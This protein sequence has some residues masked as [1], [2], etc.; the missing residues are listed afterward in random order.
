MSATGFASSP[1]LLAAILSTLAIVASGCQTTA[2]R[3]AKLESQAGSVLAS[4]KGVVV[5]KQSRDI[6]VVDTTVV[7]DDYGTAAI[8][9]LKNTSDKNIAMP[10]ITVTIPGAGK[11][12]LYTNDEPGLDPALT[13]IA[14]IEKGKPAFWV[15]DQIPLLAEKPKKSEA[16]VGKGDQVNGKI[17]EIRVGK[18][19]FFADNDGAS[20][21]GTVLNNSK[22][23][24]TKL[25]IYGIARKGGKVIGAGTGQVER[26]A[27]GRRAGFQLFL[28]GKHKGA[29]YEFY[30]PP[31]VLR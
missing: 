3:S 17:P 18:T 27:P 21:R 16:I 5:S 8:V 13:S 29:E 9:E 25:V 28:I 15:N 22:V 31:T 14:L 23:L 2:D 11:E 10:P 12:P 19:E 26:L 24:Q 20:L 1:L 7:S 4:E 30:A 6:D